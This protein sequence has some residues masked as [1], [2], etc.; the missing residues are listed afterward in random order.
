MQLCRRAAGAH[1]APESAAHVQPPPGCVRVLPPGFQAL[2]PAREM[3]DDSLDR[4]GLVRVRQR[5]EI[6]GSQGFGRRSALLGGAVAGRACC[7]GAV[8]Q[9]R[10]G[11]AAGLLRAAVLDGATAASAG[12][13]RL[14][15]VRAPP[16]GVK[17]VI[18]AVPL[19]GARAEQ[20]APAVA[21]RGMREHA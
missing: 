14:L 1:R 2:Q 21:Q 3:A 4:A 5:A 11:L 19:L 20:A 10:A 8:L 17:K 15:P 13:Q 12:F 6:R 7:I 18:E 16:V 9:N